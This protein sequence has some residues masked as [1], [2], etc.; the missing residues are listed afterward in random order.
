MN[1]DF[2]CDIGEVVEGCGGGVVCWWGG[3]GVGVSVGGGGGGGVE[4]RFCFGG[5]FWVVDIECVFVWSFWWCVVGIIL[6]LCVVWF[7]GGIG[8]V[9]CGECWVIF[10]EFFILIVVSENGIIFVFCV[11]FVFFRS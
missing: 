10:C 2:M 7:G 9:C 8:C 3:G 5:F 11:M 4:Y 6:W 1:L